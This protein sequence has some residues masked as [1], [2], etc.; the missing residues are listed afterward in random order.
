MK[1]ALQALLIAGEKMR[2]EV[3]ADKKRITI[4]EGHRDYTT[5]PVMLGCHILSWA[6]LRTITSVVYC[7]MAEV[8]KEEYQSDGFESRD[9]L[10]VGLKEF[11]PNIRWDSPVTVV[12]WEP[13]T[14]FQRGHIA[15]NK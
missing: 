3:L 10:L 1:R 13:Q 11:Y 6:T 8:T 12:R 15:Y 14:F 4:R 9:D 7:T 5:G 2:D